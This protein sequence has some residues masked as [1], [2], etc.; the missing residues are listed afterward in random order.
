MK[1]RTS[2]LPVLVLVA[3]VALVLGSIGTAV[4]APA[5]TKSK[6]KSIATKVVKKQ[7]PG[8]SVAHAT[9]ADT[10][11]SATNATNLNAL[12]ASA[13]QDNATFVA[14]SSA[15]SIPVTTD[16]QILSGNITVPAGRSLVRVTGNVSMAGTGGNFVIYVTADAVCTGV[17]PPHAVYSAVPG[18][19]GQISATVDFVFAATAATHTYRFCSSASAGQS[20]YTRTLTL[21]TLANGTRTTSPRPGGDGSG[22]LSLK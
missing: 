11:T 10:A 21:M 15:T 9:S 19:S 22:S 5:L 1:K 3:V 20:A 7:A 6:V 14:T 4:A 13:Y 12:A 17:A 16:T 18:A 8:L 2:S